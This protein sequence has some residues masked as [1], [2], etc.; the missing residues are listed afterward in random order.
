VRALESIEDYPQQDVVQLEIG[1]DKLE[2]LFN[3][4][5]LCAA[6]LRCLNC[7]SKECIWNLCLSV[8]ARRMQCKIASSKLH[9]CCKQHADILHKDSLV[10]IGLKRE[11]LVHI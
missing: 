8:C 2:A 4:G 5:A 6:D 7:A 9:E 10:T 1:L 3:T 11:Y